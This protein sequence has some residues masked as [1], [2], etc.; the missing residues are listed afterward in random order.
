MF[1]SRG[2]CRTETQILRS[3]LASLAKVASMALTDLHS[4][5][6]KQIRTTAGRPARAQA[7]WPGGECLGAAG[8]VEV[9]PRS[10][11]HC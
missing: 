11:A 7:G 4:S 10:C 6:C 3:L 8:V 9:R 1:G 5:Q 2:C